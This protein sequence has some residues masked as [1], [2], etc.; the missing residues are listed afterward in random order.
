MWR[1]DTSRIDADADAEMLAECAEA[2]G[3]DIAAIFEPKANHS[4]VRVV[5]DT[6]YYTR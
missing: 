2:G 3:R 4:R 1:S 5:K 6:S